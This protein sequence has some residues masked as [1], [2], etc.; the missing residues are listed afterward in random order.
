MI[1]IEFDD[2]KK[3]GDWSFVGLL[4]RNGIVHKYSGY[5]LSF[6]NKSWLDRATSIWYDLTGL[7]TI[8]AT[9]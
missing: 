9:K 4:N 3:F 6:P 8:G 2:S 5:K 1:E 7:K